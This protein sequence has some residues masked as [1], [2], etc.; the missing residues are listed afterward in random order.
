MT[1]TK[2]IQWRIKQCLQST[3]KKVK[4]LLQYKANASTGTPIANLFN[5][6]ESEKKVRGKVTNSKERNVEAP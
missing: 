3:E 1:T 6:S 5:A 2:N 4:E